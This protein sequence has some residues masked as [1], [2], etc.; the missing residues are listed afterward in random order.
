MTTEQ[1]FIIKAEALRDFC[2][3]V[4]EKANVPSEDAK[5]T[6]GLMVE[7][8]LR[9]VDTHGVARLAGATRSLEEGK[10]NPRPNLRILKEGPVHV[11]FDADLA[12]GYVASAKAMQWCIERAKETGFAMAG[13]RNSTHFGAAAS[14]AMMAAQENFIGFAAT[15]GPPHLAPPG[16]YVAT[17]GNN[18]SAYAI[19]A[20]AEPMLVLDIATSVKAFNLV[21]KYAREGR[22]IPLGWALDEEGNPTTDPNHAFSLMPFGE[23][24]FKGFGMTLIMDV[25]AGVMT[26]SRFG[27]RFTQGIGVRQ[28]GHFF[29]ALDPELFMPLA[30]FKA[31][32]DETLRAAKDAPRKEGVTRLFVAGEPEHDQFQRRSK[33]GIPLSPW[34]REQLETVGREFGVPFE[35]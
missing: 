22:S 2:A 21:N 11:L 18:P 27:P 7:T 20:G 24:G 29:Y 26:G 4:L 8:E 19:P 28:V 9:G 14:Y 6:A 1:Q 25:L 23:N 32:V 13:V 17:H 5:V 31:N 3:Q 15:N 12:L 33:E 35:R 34:I 16:G 10:F 30:E